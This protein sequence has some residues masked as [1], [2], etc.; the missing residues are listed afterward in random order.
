[1]PNIPLIQSQVSP[2]TGIPQATQPYATPDAFGAAVGRARQQAGG[3]L[4]GLGQVAAEIGLKERERTRNLDLTNH[5][6]QTNMHRAALDV[7]AN[8]PADA[9]PDYMHD[10]TVEALETAIE[11]HAA[12]IEDPWV[13]EQYRERMYARIPAYADN[14]TEAGFTNERAWQ[15]EQTSNSLSTLVNQV[16][17]DPLQYDDVM[18]LGNQLIAARGLSPADAAAQQQAW[19]NNAAFARF[20]GMLERANTTAEFDN[21]IHQLSDPDEEWQDELT[22]DDFTRLL[23][24]ATS[25]KASFYTESTTAARTFNTALLADILST[26]EIAPE[27]LAEGERLALASGNEVEIARFERAQR[28][29]TLRTELAGRSPAEMEA[30]ANARSG[31][32]NIMPG[33]PPELGT[34]I[35]EATRLY[36]GVTSTMLGGTLIREYGDELPDGARYGNAAFAPQAGHANVNISSINH[37]VQDSLAIAGELFGRPLI[38]N[39]GYRPATQAE[40]DAIAADGR[41]SGTP[42][43]TA[44]P[45]V[46]DSS[47]SH[48]TGVDISTAGMSPEDKGRLVNSLVIAGFTGFGEYG[49]HIHADMRSNVTGSFNAETGWGGWTNLSPEVTQALALRGFAPGRSSAEIDRSGGAAIRARTMTP[50]DYTVGNEESSALGPFQFTTGAWMDLVNDGVTA[51]YIGLT[52]VINTLDDDPDVREAQILALRTSP[53]WATLMAAALANKNQRGLQEGLNRAI[54]PAEVD[55]AHFFG[56]TGATAFLTA[57]DSGNRD[58]P[59][60]NVLP[61]AAAVNREIFYNADGTPRSVGEVYA[62]VAGRWSTAPNQVAMEDADFIRAYAAQTETRIAADPMNHAN[63]TGQIVLN[64]LTQDGGFEQRGLI[65]ARVAGD[66]NIDVGDMQPFTADEAARLT[67]MQ[68]TASP[69]EMLALA[70]EIYKMDTAAPGMADAAMAQIGLDNSVHGYAAAVA[71]NLGD[72]QTAMQISNGE[73]FRRDNP[74][75]AAA[76][77]GTDAGVRIQA[78]ESA[79]GVALLGI[80]QVEQERMRHAAEAHYLATAQPGQAFDPGRFQQSVNAVIGGIVTGTPA[81]GDVNSIPTLLPPGVSASQ[82][83]TA[84]DTMTQTDLV[85]LSVDGNGNPIQQPPRWGAFNPTDDPNGGVVG[86]ADIQIE[87]TFRAVGGGLYEIVMSEGRV[88]TTLQPGGLPDTYQAYLIRFDKPIVDQLNTRLRDAGG[89]QAATAN[90]PLPANFLQLP[91]LEQERI[92]FQRLVNTPTVPPVAAASP[93]ALPGPPTIPAAPL[94]AVAAPT[95]TPA[96]V[97][98]PPAAVAAPPAAAAPAVVP[99]PA[100]AA[101]PP[102]ANLGGVEAPLIPPAALLGGATREVPFA[103]AVPEVDNERPNAG[104]LER[105]AEAIQYAQENPVEDIDDIDVEQV[106]VQMIITNRTRGQVLQHYA[107]RFA[108]PIGEITRRVR[109]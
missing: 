39:S 84:I 97:A 89:V 34:A 104:A 103:D 16:R 90:D 44:N 8:A 87:G 9:G 74:E 48:G 42:Q 57:Y 6:I 96:A 88:L 37:Q 19:R 109:P 68:A 53:H 11:D 70:A 24:R 26:T 17:S 33:L 59:A 41:V 13:R 102:T 66:Y 10:T 1:M 77:L 23:S 65:A 58:Q 95:A 76:R 5:I 28:N 69:S 106:A 22:P 2:L 38:L 36:P 92:L 7:Q 31:G 62:E 46:G 98:A 21:V 20:E 91:V 61:A 82:M 52:A 25:G 83:D 50:V 4:I 27:R 32:G 54:A 35:T 45:A 56:L 108:V 55:M 73:V 12:T 3:S 29:L 99:V 43:S 18:E 107:E 75:V 64:D 30:L 79:T 100:G 71:H 47:H 40:A 80:S 63:A 72:N 101:Q 85:R 93:I 49:N 15:T 60:A 78:F 86:V 81:I 94:P 67:T 105:R 51:D 14:A